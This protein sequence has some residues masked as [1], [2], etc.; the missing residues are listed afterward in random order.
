[1]LF[2]NNNDR[3]LGQEKYLHFYYLSSFNLEEMGEKISSECGDYV[4]MQF[5]LAVF[6]SCF[7]R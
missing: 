4:S 2:S 3:Y 6:D 5:V 7:S 1:M